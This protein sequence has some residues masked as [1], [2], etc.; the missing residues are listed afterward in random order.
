MWREGRDRYENVG[1][2][3]RGKSPKRCGER[4]EGSCAP[5]NF[6]QERK[7]RN[8]CSPKNFLP[9]VR[10]VGLSCRHKVQ[11]GL[12]GSRPSAHVKDG[13]SSAVQFAIFYR[14]NGKAGRDEELSARGAGLA[15]EKRPL[16]QTVFVAMSATKA[17][18]SSR[19]GCDPGRQVDLRTSF[20][21]YV[22]STGP[23]ARTDLRPE[24]IV[25]HTPAFQL[26]RAPSR[27][28]ASHSGAWN[29]SRKWRR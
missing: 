13:S 26:R 2:C 23:T 29:D 7:T 14:R 6:V 12:L 25:I 9:I 11:A 27:I 10:E 28:G 20:V 18:T 4:C 8:V 5:L 1:R 17:I 16:T 21:K 3:V 19:Y 22:L 24:I 15:R